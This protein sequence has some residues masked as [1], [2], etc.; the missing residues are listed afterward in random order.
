L[1]TQ[2]ADV[3]VPWQAAEV[4]TNYIICKNAEIF[5]KYFSERTKLCEG[6]KLDNILEFFGIIFF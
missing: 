3:V 5:N 4:H 2:N 6:E 1:H